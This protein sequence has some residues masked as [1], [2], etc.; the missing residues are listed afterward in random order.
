MKIDSYIKRW[1]P[2]SDNNNKKS[3]DRSSYCCRDPINFKKVHQ[4]NIYNFTSF[5]STVHQSKLNFA[6]PKILLRAFRNGVIE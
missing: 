6:K 2:V 4:K 3:C 1:E 5:R